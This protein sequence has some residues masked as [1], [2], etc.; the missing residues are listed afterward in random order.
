LNF[1]IE[2]SKKSFVNKHDK[3]SVDVLKDINIDIKSKQFVC[4][5]GPSGCGKTTL[6]NIIG[7]LID[8]ESQKIVVDNKELL[9]DKNFGYVFQTSRL[10]P[11]LTVKEN[12]ELVC[13]DDLN[14]NDRIEDLLVNFKLKDFQNYYPKSISGGMRRKVSLARALVRNPKIL[15]MDEP[16][17]SLDQPTAENLYKVLINYWKKNPITVI[18]ITHNLK[19]AILLGDRIL[20]FSKRPATV[21]YDHIV[22]SKRGDLAIDDKYIENEYISLKKKFPS[23][24]EGLI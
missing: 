23:L 14:N 13:D 18:L 20:F 1:K 6:M 17:V 9:I 22:K 2:I 5:V 15:L 21:V 11:W 19:E 16:F 10:F 24:L 3:S 8:G 4:I 7:G 12:I